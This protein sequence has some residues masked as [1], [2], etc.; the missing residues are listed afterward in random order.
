MIE[1]D[2]GTA[3]N[4]PLRMDSQFS[5]QVELWVHEAVDGGVRTFSELLVVLPGVYPTIAL[6]ALRRLVGSGT[7]RPFVLD[8]ILAEVGRPPLTTSRRTYRRA[9]LPLPHPLDYEWRFA[10][11]ASA[12]LLVEGARLAVPGQPIALIGAPSCLWEAHAWSYSHPLLLLDRNV[13]VLESLAACTIASDRLV[14]CNMHEDPL[15]DLAVSVVVLD[16]PWYNADMRAFLWAAS[17]LCQVG[18]HVI[19]SLPPVGTRPRIEH[20]RVDLIGWARAVGL[21]LMRIQAATLP[22]VSPLFER[23]ALAA[24]QLYT[25]PG[26]W[27]R[28]DLAV[29]GRKDASLPSRPSVPQR[30]ERWIEE[31]VHRVRFRIKCVE[32]DTNG[33]GDPTLLSVVTGDILPSVS[34][35]DPRRNSVDVWTSGNRV[36]RCP[37]PHTF[38][39]IVRAVSTGREADTEI[40]A[41]IGRRLNGSE[42]AAVAQATRQVRG[43]VARECEE[44]RCIG[45]E[46]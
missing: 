25:V 14:T 37:D 1:V 7:L 28:G 46:Q 6:A 10:S 27:R 26:E 45:E 23:N 15:P 3:G 22:Y 17:R 5:R 44:A 41:A 19:M 33:L 31:S 29:F 38:A 12:R 43:I 40:A 32:A 34:R 21:V 42:A 4:V 24:E 13:S 35:R 2:H 36:F 16:A 18:G 9:P 8:Q 20:D 11:A 30:D 39:R